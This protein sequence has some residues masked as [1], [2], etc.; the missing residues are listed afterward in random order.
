MSSRFKKII[1]YLSTAVV[2]GCVLIVFVIHPGINDNKPSM[3]ADTIYGKASKPFVYR[4]LLPTTVRVLSAPVPQRL[5]N[6]IANKIEEN[7]SLRKLFLKL[8]WEK[9]YAVEYSI[10]MLLMFLSLWGFSIAVKNLFS[11][12]FK[13]NEWFAGSVS[14]IAL[15][16]LPPMFEYTSFVYDFP[17]LLLYTLGLIFLY[18]QDW[19]SFLIIFLIG[20]INKETTILLALI[21]YIYYKSKLIKDMFNKLL[22]AQIGIFVVVKAFLFTVFVNNRGTFI[23]FHLVD[24]NL[25]LLTGYDLTIVASLLGL[26]LLVFYKWNEKPNFLKT[27]LWAF[28]PLVVLTLFLGYLDELRDYYEVYPSVILLL[29]YSISKIMN[30]KIEILD[31]N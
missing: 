15:A 2:S 8:K 5:K 16:G 21:F 26:I 6:S 17:L 4:T 19:K 9:E 12:F 11:L 1:Y 31:K 25:R 7:V 18:K 27:T 3:F 24:H 30:V 10:A 29:S 23:E 13:T 14:I 28:I 20:C 22:A